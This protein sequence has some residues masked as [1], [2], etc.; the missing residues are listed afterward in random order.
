MGAG[1]VDM[2]VR[3]RGVVEQA[4]G[5]GGGGGTT[6]AG[7]GGEARGRQ[8]WRSVRQEG[9]AARI[10]PPERQ[11]RGPSTAPGRRG[12]HGTSGVLVPARRAASAVVMASTL[13]TNL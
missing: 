10:Q 13:A 9:R 12:Q 4:G 8:L 11:R 7:P 5:G 1:A 6:D 2:G 3:L